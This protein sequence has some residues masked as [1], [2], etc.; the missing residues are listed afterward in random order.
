SVPLLERLRFL[1]IVSS[2]LDE[3]FEIRV[4]GIKEQIRLGLRTPG[5][6]GLTPS[7]LLEQVS[8]EVHALIARQYELLNDDILPA[9]EAE[10]VVFLRRGDWTEEQAR[11][12]EDYFD[13]EVSPVLTP[14]GL[15]QAHPFPRVLNKSLNF[16]VELEGRDAFGRDS[17]VAVVQAPRALPRVIRLPSEIAGC[18]YGF[19]FLSSILHAHVGELFS[20]MQVKG[21]YQCRVTRDSDLTVDD[22]AVKDLRI[23]L[24]GEL[25]HRQY[26]EAVRLE[27]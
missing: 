3:F 2:N 4:S 12:I 25:S 20:G 8:A 7:E 26:G 5:I 19:I 17:G 10:G 24:Q 27:V 11:W 9:L 23:A 14:I 18:E 1:C 16:A 6:D 13:R 15:D 21:C 22:E